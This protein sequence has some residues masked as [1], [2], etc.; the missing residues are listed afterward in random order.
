[1]T[2]R[3]I[4]YSVTPFLYIQ[5]TGKLV[6]VYWSW[7]EQDNERELLNQLTKILEEDDENNQ[8]G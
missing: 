5:R 8:T 6:K 2:L 1:M 3:K 4:I 7:Y